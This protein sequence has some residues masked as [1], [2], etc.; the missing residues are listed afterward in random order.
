MYRKSAFTKFHKIH[1]KMSVLESLLQKAFR[2]MRFSVAFVK[3]LR[4]T[5]LLYICE[6][7]TG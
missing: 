5:L 6:R 3:Y 1:R 4:T 7:V 2:H